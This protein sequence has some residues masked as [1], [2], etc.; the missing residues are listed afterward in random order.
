MLDHQPPVVQRLKRFPSI[1]VYWSRIV[2]PFLAAARGSIG[3]KLLI[4][5][6]RERKKERN[7]VVSYIWLL[8][9]CLY[10]V[11]IIELEERKKERK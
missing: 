11:D 6:G 10:T 5:H 7:P 9:L 4:S 2:E 8:L 3:R 1:L